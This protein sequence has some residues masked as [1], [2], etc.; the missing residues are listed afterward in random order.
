MLS[1]FTSFPGIYSCGWVGEWSNTLSFFP[2]NTLQQAEASL[3]HQSA[4]YSM[5]FVSHSCSLTLD[6]LSHEIT[7]MA[8]QC[9][10]VACKRA[11]Q[12][13]VQFFWCSKY[14]TSKTNR[15]GCQDPTMNSK[16]ALL[17]AALLT[18]FFDGWSQRSEPHDRLTVARVL[19][20]SQTLLHAPLPGELVGTIGPDPTNEI[21]NHHPHC[22]RKD[23]AIF[24]HAKSRDHLFF[25][26]VSRWLPRTLPASSNASL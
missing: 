3:Q 14:E 6:C 8:N 12:V 23:A 5:Q 20:R 16:I 26:F 17:H 19:R 11:S 10:H 7:G 1:R 4:E 22:S 21:S 24:G 25:E 18:F 2:P 13:A 9:R 15:S